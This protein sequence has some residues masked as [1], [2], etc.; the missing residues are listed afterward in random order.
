MRRHTTVTRP[1]HD[2]HATEA[3]PASSSGENSE[4][5]LPSSLHESVAMVRM[6]SI[7]ASPATISRR[8]ASPRSGDSGGS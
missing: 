4:S 8:A 7:S 6:S 3:H 5:V 2:R 1:S